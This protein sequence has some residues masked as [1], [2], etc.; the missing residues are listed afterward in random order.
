M[1]GTVFIALI[2]LVLLLFLGWGLRDESTKNPESS[3]NNYEKPQFKPLTAE[4]IKDIHSRGKITPAEMVEEW[5][6]HGLCAPGDGMGGASW[7][8]KKFRHNCHDCL[9]DYANEIG[10]KVSIKEMMKAQKHPR[11]IR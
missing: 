8:C 5:E 2:L 10:E 9:V 6:A 4:E 7:R 1:F 3:S 11:V